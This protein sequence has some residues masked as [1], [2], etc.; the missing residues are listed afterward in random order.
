M[1]SHPST[2]S[3]L[4]PSPLSPPPI[5]HTLTTRYH[6][7][8][9]VE[10]TGD[11]SKELELTAETLSDDGKNYHAWQHRQWVIRVRRG[12][13]G[14]GGGG[15]GA[16]QQ[17]VIRVRS[18]RR[19]D[20][21]GII[22]AHTCIHTAPHTPPSSP[23]TYPTLPTIDLWP[24]GRGAG[25]CRQSVAEGPPEQ[26]SLESEVLCRQQHYHLHRGGHRQRSQVHATSESLASQSFIW[27][28][29]S[30]KALR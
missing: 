27:N 12:G 4:P 5:P 28:V 2:L 20:G 7:Q 15:G 10:W 3:S 18:G 26:L 14:G 8:K 9:V 17:W 6:R 30:S 23:T 22:L 13:G 19:G 11:A 16:W 24:V 25:V 21:F 1:S 29:P